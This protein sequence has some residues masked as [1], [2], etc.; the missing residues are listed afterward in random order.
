[1]EKNKK[2]LLGLASVV[3]VYSLVRHSKVGISLGKGLSKLTNNRCG[4]ITTGGGW[5]I[6]T[7]TFTCDAKKVCESRDADAEAIY[8]REYV[9]NQ[10][11]ARKSRPIDTGG[12][13]LKQY[14]A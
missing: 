1:M 2:I 5:K 12:V 6:Y 10:C 8:G 4:V 11:N 14:P 13:V 7:N 9:D 3:V